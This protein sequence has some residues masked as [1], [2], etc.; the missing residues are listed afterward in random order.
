MQLETARAMLAVGQDASSWDTMLEATESFL[1]TDADVVESW[2]GMA[3]QR[4]LPAVQ[5]ATK[6][7]S[8][9]EARCFLTYGGKTVEAPSE[10][11]VDV[12]L[13]DIHTLA[14]LVKNDLEIRFCVD[15]FH[16]SDLAFLALPPGDWRALEKE[17]GVKGVAFRFLPLAR[18]LD[19]FEEQAFSDENNRYYGE[20]PEPTEAEKAA[21]ALLDEVAAIV[22]PLVPYV[23]IIADLQPGCGDSLDVT[24]VTQ[25]DSERDA[26]ARDR[27]RVRT[28]IDLLTRGSQALG[29]TLVAFG[30][31]SQQTVDRNFH[32]IW[33]MPAIEAAQNLIPPRRVEPVHMSSDG[34]VCDASDESYLTATDADSQLWG[35]PVR[36]SDRVVRLACNAGTINVELSEALAPFVAL[37]DGRNEIVMQLEYPSG[38][39]SSNYGAAKNIAVVLAPALAPART[40][41]E[42]IVETAFQEKPAKAPLLRAWP[43]PA[44][45]DGSRRYREFSHPLSERD[46]TVF[47]APDGA[48]VLVQDDIPGSLTTYRRHSQHL[49]VTC[50][51]GKK[52]AARKV[53]DLV[54]RFLDENIKVS[55]LG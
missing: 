12:R 14:R 41:A 44:A 10:H 55:V 4:G 49:Q 2:N 21:N 5:V 1:W 33:M 37:G 53:D 26:I 16:S 42:Q 29:R 52:F 20:E 39:P 13:V 45:Q 7:D 50:H 43:L 30:V 36:C 46:L 27:Q 11:S 51:C 34:V 19:K 3:A 17:F 9:D 6:G 18:S 31:Q 28:M 23:Q 32:G 35:K 40:R 38:S 54:V 8:A 22:K 47:E 25:T 15:S 48:L 24:L